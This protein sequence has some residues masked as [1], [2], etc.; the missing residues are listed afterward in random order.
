MEFKLLEL[1]GWPQPIDNHGC[2][3]TVLAWFLPLQVTLSNN[4]QEMLGGNKKVYYSQGLEIRQQTWGYT[5]RVMIDRRREREQVWGFALI[6]RWKPRVSAD[7]CLISEFQTQERKLKH[8]KRKVK[9]PQRSVM[10][11][12]QDV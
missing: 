4:H 2:G 11:I 6:R 8:W 9:W 7:S 3:Q 1:G 10:E 5:A 12:S